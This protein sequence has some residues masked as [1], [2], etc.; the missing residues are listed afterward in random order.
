MPGLERYSSGQKRNPV[1]KS[2]KGNIYINRETS[3]F[4][5]CSNI[6]ALYCYKWVADKLAEPLKYVSL[7]TPESSSAN[8]VHPHILG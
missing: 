4:E 3:A 7:F 5:L 1:L 8:N 2:V 6:S